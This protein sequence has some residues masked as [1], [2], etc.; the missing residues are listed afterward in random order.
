MRGFSG[1]LSTR[2]TAQPRNEY[3]SEF[4]IKAAQLEH[5]SPKFPLSY[6]RISVAGHRICAAFLTAGDICGSCC[7][8]RPTGFFSCPVVAITIGLAMFFGFYPVLAI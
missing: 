1:Q 6:G 8:T 2:W 5:A 7:F 3:A 4:V